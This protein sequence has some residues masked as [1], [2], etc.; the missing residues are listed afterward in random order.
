MAEIQLISHWH[1]LL[2]GFRHSPKAFY[3]GLEKSIKTREIP[4]SGVSRV[5][6][7]EGGM[8]SAKREYLRVRRREHIFDICAA[9]FGSGFFVSWWLF[10]TP[11]CLSI[12]AD[13]PIVGLPLA[14][15]VR[16]TT[17][18]ALDSAHMFQG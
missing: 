2:D 11:G 18:W 13:I 5:E 4:D 3:E 17:Y 15:F 6:F 1:H 8:L 14:P 12:L 10:T 7:S 9:P 16:R